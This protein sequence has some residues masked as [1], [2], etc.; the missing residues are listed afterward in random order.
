MSQMWKGREGKTESEGARLNR[1]RELVDENEGETSH[2]KQQNLLKVN[3]GTQKKGGEGRGEET[4]REYK[5]L[6]F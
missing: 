5:C 1:K 6:P 2:E 3:R 4:E